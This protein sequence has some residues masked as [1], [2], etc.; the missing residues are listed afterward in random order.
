MFDRHKLAIGDEILSL[1]NESLK[2]MSH[3]ETI[4][5]FKTIKEGPVVLEIARRR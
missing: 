5:M 1:N 3:L 2:G 4:A